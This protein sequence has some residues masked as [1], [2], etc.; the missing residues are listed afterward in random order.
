MSIL[1]DLPVFRKGSHGLT[2]INTDL[3]EAEEM[4]KR[5]AEDERTRNPRDFAGNVSCVYYKMPYVQPCE[6]FEELRRLIERVRE[7]TGL[8]ADFRGIVAI[9]AVEWLGHE[10]EEYFTVLL[11]YLYDMRDVWRAAIVLKEATHA[12]I[13]RMA[14][15]CSDVITPRPFEVRVFTQPE[16]L[17]ALL[18]EAFQRRG[19]KADGK[20]IGILAQVLARPE[21]RKARS[22]AMIERTVEELTDLSAGREEVTADAVRE[23]VM[24]P[25]SALTMMAGKVLIPE[26]SAEI[27]EEKIHI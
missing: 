23:Y 7:N 13:Q 6:P 5:L 25:W 4:V 9:E 15:A 8:R 11:K 20:A 3:A 19:V 26:R 2:L 10:K 16:R 18:H 14:S 27:E 22:L 24:D 12:Q 1:Q 21:L 17:C